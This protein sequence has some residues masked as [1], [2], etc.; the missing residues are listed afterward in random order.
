MITLG[1]STPSYTIGVFVL[2]NG[3]FDSHS[4]DTMGLCS[5]EG[6]AVLLAFTCI[7]HVVQ[8]IKTLAESTV[9][10]DHLHPISDN[11]HVAGQVPEYSK[12]AVPSSVSC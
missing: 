1:S 7:Q 10:K 3:L 4:R 5:N 6:H 2:K 8:H 9:R 11:N 12:P